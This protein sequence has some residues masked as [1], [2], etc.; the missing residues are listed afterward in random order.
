MVKVS[1]WLRFFI[2]RLLLTDIESTKNWICKYG[3]YFV[4][5]P[6]P[7]LCLGALYIYKKK[8]TILWY[9][10]QDILTIDHNN[11]G[12]C[13][14]WAIRTVNFY[15]YQKSSLSIIK[16]NWKCFICVLN[17]QSFNQS[18]VSTKFRFDKQR[19]LK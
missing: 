19:V 7:N 8:K 2:Y 1:E 18:H 10:L 14:T 9:T 4:K 15:S 16:H 13:Q 12:N 3:K 11:L 17:R 5:N 6:S